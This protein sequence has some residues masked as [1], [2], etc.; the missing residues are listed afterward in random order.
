MNRN[1]FIL[2]IIILMCVYAC[3]PSKEEFKK[4]QEENNGLKKEKTNL[5]VEIKKLQHTLSQ[6]KK[7]ARL[8][9]GEALIQ[10]NENNLDQAKAKLV[11]LIGN[12]P[13]SEEAP[14]AGDLLEKI[15]SKKSELKEIDGNQRLAALTIALEANLEYREFKNSCGLLSSSLVSKI[16][17]I[18]LKKEVIT[19]TIEYKAHLENLSSKKKVAMMHRNYQ[20]YLKSGQSVFVLSVINNEKLHL[21][22]KIYFKNLKNNVRLLSEDRKQYRVTKF[23][24]NFAEPLNPGWNRGYLY[25]DNF[26]LNKK[27]ER[28]SVHFDE[29]YVNCDEDAE[30]VSRWAFSFDE[31]EVNYL[32]L[33]QAGLSAEEVRQKYVFTPHK[34][35]GLDK[36]DVLGIIKLILRVLA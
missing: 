18:P 32:A 1:I 14:L 28:Y 3:G 12:H 33:L 9:Y 21:D 36:E 5:K 15:K 25:F 7:E 30:K 4:L 16:I 22:A 35:V 31:S 34:S 8:L 6:T 11:V 23:T 27:V 10:F 29:F 17:L 13:S 20:E 24:Q 26:R 2:L 19:A